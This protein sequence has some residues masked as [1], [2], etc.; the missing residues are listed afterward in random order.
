MSIAGASVVAG[1]NASGR[2][3]D[4]ASSIATYENGVFT[5]VS[6]GTVVYRS[7]AGELGTV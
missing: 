1:Y 7:A 6:A 2:E 5:A 3:V 4:D